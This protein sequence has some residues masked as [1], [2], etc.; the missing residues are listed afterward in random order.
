MTTVISKEPLAQEKD[1][2]RRRHITSNFESRQLSECDFPPFLL[3]A[4]W[5]RSEEGA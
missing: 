5:E 3:N 4:G 2:L 1:E